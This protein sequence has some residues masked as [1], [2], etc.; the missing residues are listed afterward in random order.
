MNSM[1]K[2]YIYSL[3]ALL[4]TSCGQSETDKA[5]S[6]LDEARMALADEEFDRARTLIDSLRLTYP[7]ELDVRRAAIPFADSLELSLAK[8]ELSASDSILVFKEL[9]LA[10]LK[11]QFVFEKQERFQTTG[12]YVTPDYAGSKSSYTF[13][14]EVEETGALLAVNITRNGKDINY[15]F[16][17]VKIDFDSSLIPACPLSRS[18]T[19]KEQASYEKCYALARCIQECNQAKE[20]HEKSSLKVRFFEKKLS[21]PLD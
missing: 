3:L 1:K 9:E 10:D 17:E 15:V 8:H 14:P 20:T 2:L 11:K 7:N 6:L 18:L 21:Q 4:F 19:D 5:S 16:N 12:Y 13:F